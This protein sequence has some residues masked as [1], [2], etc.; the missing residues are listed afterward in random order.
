VL[1]G[2]VFYSLKEAQIII[3]NWRRHCSTMRPHS[4]LGY[5]PPAAKAVVPVDDNIPMH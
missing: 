4:A 2:E 3:E 5:R 1:N